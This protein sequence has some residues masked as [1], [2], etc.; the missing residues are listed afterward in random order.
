MHSEV[1]IPAGNFNAWSY[2]SESGAEWRL[3]EVSD[4]RNV[5]QHAKER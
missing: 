1:G 2:D 5:E 4:A 3:Q